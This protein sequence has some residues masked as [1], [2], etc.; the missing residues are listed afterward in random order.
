MAGL[1]RP[2]VMR[3]PTVWRAVNDDSFGYYDGSTW[4]RRSEPPAGVG[5]MR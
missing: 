4:A 2:L 3:S 1:Y 5:A